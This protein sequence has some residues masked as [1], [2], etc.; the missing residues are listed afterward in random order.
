MIVRPFVRA[1]SSCNL[2]TASHNI[3]PIFLT[4]LLHD[5]LRFLFIAQTFH[6]KEATIL[7]GN[8]SLCSERI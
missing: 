8:I 7:V 3:A 6:R 2:I 4:S 1:T 5:S